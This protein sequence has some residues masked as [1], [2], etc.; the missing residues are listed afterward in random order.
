MAQSQAEQARDPTLLLTH[1]FRSW[2]HTPFQS[3]WSLFPTVSHLLSGWW[4]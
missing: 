4:Q 1:H 2:V 3:C